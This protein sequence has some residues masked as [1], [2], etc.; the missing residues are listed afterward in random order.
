[1]FTFAGIPT[2]SL[3]QPSVLLNNCRRLTLELSQKK[4]GTDPKTGGNLIIRG[5]EIWAGYSGCDHWSAGMLVQSLCDC[6]LQI[7]ANPA[8]FVALAPTRHR[9]LLI[10]GSCL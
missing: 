8:L 1:M 5:L 2:Q 3:K 9:E 7:P 4:K 6:N 10:T